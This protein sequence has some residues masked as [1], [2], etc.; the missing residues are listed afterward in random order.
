MGFK[1]GIVLIGLLVLMGCENTTFISSVPSYPVY[2]EM[3]L[4]G[5]YVHFMSSA[6]FQYYTFTERRYPTQ[7]LG[8]SGLLVMNAMDGNYYAC[9]LCCPHCVSRQNAVEVDGFY[10]VCPTCG[11]TYDLS[12][13][14]CIPTKGIT[15]E[16]LRQYMVT[17]TGDKLIIRQ[18]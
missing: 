15:R 2:W 9:D 1:K 14:L 6:V 18:K 7:A 17:Y 8:Y 4:K 13:G 12:Y 10:A 5:E 16:A 11:E 3:D